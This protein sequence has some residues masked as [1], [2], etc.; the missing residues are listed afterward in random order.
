MTSVINLQGTQHVDSQGINFPS[1]LSGFFE[2]EGCFSVSFSRN[3]K[4][5]L[6]WEVRPSVSVSQNE[7]RRQIVDRTKSY[8][9]CG[10]IRRDL[11]DKTVKW[12]CRSVKEIQSIILPHFDLY[13]L[14]TTKNEDVKS[15][16]NVVKM[17][18]N[19]EHLT[20]AGLIEIIGIVKEMNPDGKRRI[21]LADI[22]ATLR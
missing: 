21:A 2:G 5:K 18:S 17:M 4:F 6:K 3:I 14:I 16:R 19:N 20:R 15:L 10:F 22:L 8:F 1:Y 7:S 9:G 13:P 12:E 11:S